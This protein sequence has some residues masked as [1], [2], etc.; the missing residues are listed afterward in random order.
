M[1]D[2]NPELLI[3]EHADLRGVSSQCLLENGRLAL[4]L[5]LAHPAEGGGDLSKLSEIEV[6]LVTDEVIA[7]VHEDF[8]NDPSPT[9]VITFHH[10]EIF[11]SLDTAEREG[12]KFGHTTE[13]EALL[14]LIH[15]LLHL[16]GHD[17]QT[18]TEREVMKQLQEEILAKILNP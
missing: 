9:D 12:V 6:N 8:M 7:Q 15:G 5:C 1:T 2:I 11:I 14:Y 17:D 18:T 3:F 13:Q 10:G 16:N 4:P